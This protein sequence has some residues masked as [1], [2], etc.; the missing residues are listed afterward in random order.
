L[1]TGLGLYMSAKIINE[2]FNGNIFVKN[3]EILHKDEI[4]I[5]AK[6]YIEM[7]KI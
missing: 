1:G 7:G 2:H 6:F 5:G 4:Y 3:E